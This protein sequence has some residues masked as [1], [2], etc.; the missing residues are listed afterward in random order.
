MICSRQGLPPDRV[1]L[2]GRVEPQGWAGM[3]C[4][5]RRACFETR[6]GRVG[7]LLGMSACFLVALR[8][9]PH[10]VV[11]RRPRRP[12]T[13]LYILRTARPSHLRIQQVFQADEG[14]PAHVK[15]DAA[16]YFSFI[17]STRTSRLLSGSFQNGFL[18]RF[19]LKQKIY[20]RYSNP[21]PT[22]HQTS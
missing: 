15:H 11:A 16:R 7:S 4:I 19:C 18:R 6:S 14:A 3:R 9:I 2:E 10:P 22:I 20:L 1:K 21:L 5:G 12:C 17:R 13:V 8:Q